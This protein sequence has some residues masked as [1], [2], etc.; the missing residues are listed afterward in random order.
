VIEALQPV[1]NMVVFRFRD[2]M[3]IVEFHQRIVDALRAGNAGAAADALIGQMQ[4]L[5]RM[6]EAAQRWRRERAAPGTGE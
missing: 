5:E 3:Q 4:Y 1:I 6:I 2:R